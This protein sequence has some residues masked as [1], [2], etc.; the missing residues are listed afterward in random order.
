VDVTAAGLLRAEKFRAAPPNKA[1]AWERETPA[2]QSERR[3]REKGTA[4]AHKGAEKQNST[5]K[6]EWGIYHHNAT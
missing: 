4:G 1:S 2:S 6:E 3:A 5:R